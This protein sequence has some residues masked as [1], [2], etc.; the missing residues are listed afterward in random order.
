MEH[1]SCAVS[2]GALLKLQRGWQAG[3][4]E[5]PMWKGIGREMAARPAL[6]CFQEGLLSGLHVQEAR[7]DLPFLC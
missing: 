4:V 7:R 5:G 1:V 3:K 6:P 2:D